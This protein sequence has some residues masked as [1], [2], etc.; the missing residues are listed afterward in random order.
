MLLPDFLLE[1]ELLGGIG[2]D[3]VN[4]TG[5]GRTSKGRTLRSTVGL[6]LIDAGVIGHSGDGIIQVLQSGNASLSQGFP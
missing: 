2:S 6:H 4:C 3:I 1:L 5:K